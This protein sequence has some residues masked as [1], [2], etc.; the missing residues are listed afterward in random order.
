MPEPDASR[1]D[2]TVVMGAESGD[3]DLGHEAELVKTA[4]L[5][6]DHVELVS[7]KAA[8]VQAALDLLAAPERI[9]SA[10]LVM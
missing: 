8:L 5:Y 6:A 1:F 10:N 4:L 7:P 2:I 3:I 9:R